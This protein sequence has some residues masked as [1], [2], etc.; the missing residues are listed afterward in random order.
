MPPEL[1][2]YNVKV[3]GKHGD[4]IFESRC[5]WT[6]GLSDRYDDQRL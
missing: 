4:N 3:N 6:G 5:R 1:W 2:R